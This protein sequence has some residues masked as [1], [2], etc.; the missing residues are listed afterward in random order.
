MGSSDTGWKLNFHEFHADV[1]D[2]SELNRPLRDSVILVL[3]TEWGHQCGV[4][5]VDA[6]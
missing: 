1:L 6:L 2:V 4:W 5:T 3:C